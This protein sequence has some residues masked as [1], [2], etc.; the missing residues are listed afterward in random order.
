MMSQDSVILVSIDSIRADHCGY[1]KYDRETTPNLDEMAA[2]GL[3]FT[4]A[5]A[6]G[7]RTPESMPSIFTG[8]FLSEDL[9]SDMVDQRV[10]VSEHMNK[11]TTIPERFSRAGYQTVGITP[12]PFTS[13][14]FGFDSGF[15]EFVD[16]LGDEGSGLYHRLFNGWL[17]GSTTS[18]V[19]RLARN[20]IIREEVFKPWEAY[21]DRVAETIH[22]GK[23]PYFLWVFLM[24][25][26]EPYL[27]AKDYQSQSWLDRWR[28]I[29]SLYLGDRESEFDEA[30]RK[31]LVNAYD[32]SIRYADAFLAQLRSDIG[33]DTVVAVHGDHGEAFGEH[34]Y[35]SHEPYLYEESIHVPLVV[36]GA[37]ERQIERPMSLRELPSLLTRLS[38]ADTVDGIG[39]DVA[40]ART[41]NGGAVA[42]RTRSKKF[43]DGA[44]GA[45]LYRIESDELTEADSEEAQR[46]FSRLVA[47]RREYTRERRR[48]HRAAEAF[49][50]P[51]R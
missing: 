36:H 26:H 48:I 40:E 41:A 9:P 49:E 27:A 22:E 18:K 4:N 47:T 28:A 3:T 8:Q 32:D 2:E 44:D 6:P 29:W 33:D 45:E 20:M 25:V 39:S 35:Y 19:L 24:D 12:N 1:M 30:T 23:E 21:Y 7:P 11:R 42:L 5:V 46:L 50:E 15:D 10:F 38:R 31:R 16:F 14:Y 34:G 37:G 13:R 43:I 51:S 17:D